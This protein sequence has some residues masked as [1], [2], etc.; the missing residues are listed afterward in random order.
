EELRKAK[1]KAEEADRKKSVFLA[2]VNHEIRTPLNAFVGFSNLLSETDNPSEQKEYV[3]IIQANNELLLQLI[4]DTLDLARIE[5]GMSEF[6]YTDVNLNTLLSH[7]EQ[8]SR[9]KLTS[10]VEIVF[11]KK[12]AP[13]VIRTDKNRLSQVI[14]NLIDNALKFT[15]KGRVCFGYRKREQEQDVYFYVSDTGMGISKEQ[16]GD[17]FER[18]VKLNPFMQGTGLGLPVSRSIVQHLGGEIGAESEYG[19]GSTFWFTLPLGSYV[20]N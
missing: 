18:F 3:D 6:V 20:A 16:L 19:A 10:E 8:A 11:E 14:S 12:Q 13:C 15:K 2:N 5:A 1:E 9:I 7:I 4:N 17:V